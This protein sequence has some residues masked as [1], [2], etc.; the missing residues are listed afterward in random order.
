MAETKPTGKDIKDGTIQRADLDV[1]TSG[2]AVVAKLVAGAGITFSSTG[3][4][5]G[6][7]DVTINATGSAMSDGY[8]L[9]RIAIGL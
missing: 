5:A 7:G 6:T 4:D 1:S 8:I 3:P 2:S 9:A